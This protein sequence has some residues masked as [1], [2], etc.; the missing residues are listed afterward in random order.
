MP[1]QPLRR[2][3]YLYFTYH[4]H[5]TEKNIVPCPLALRKTL[6]RFNLTQTAFYCVPRH[7]PASIDLNALCS[8]LFHCVFLTILCFSSC[9]IG[10]ASISLD[11]LL[12][13]LD[14]IYGHTPSL[15]LLYSITI[16]SDIHHF[17]HPFHHISQPRNRFYQPFAPFRSFI[18]FQCYISVVVVFWPYSIAGCITEDL[19]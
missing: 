11:L 13:T 18:S 10:F 14:C 1:F 9:F 15:T 12:P 6:Y 2:H 3:Y 4:S 7:Y 16:E 17:Y 19:V 8:T 5:C